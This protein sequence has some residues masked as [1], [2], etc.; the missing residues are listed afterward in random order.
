MPDWD[1]LEQ[2]LLGSIN[3]HTF[4]GGIGGDAYDLGYRR[5]W[6][7]LPEPKEQATA[8]IAQANGIHLRGPAVTYWLAALAM[9][10]FNRLQVA[11][12]LW[13]EATHAPDL[14]DAGWHMGYDQRQQVA[15]WFA[16]HR[17]MARLLMLPVPLRSKHSDEA[18]AQLPPAR[19]EAGGQFQ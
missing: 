8:A 2:T 7:A 9:E 14:A 3:V 15:N 5:L 11:M 6:D 18:W 12:L 1:V 13:V 16:A 17:A 10:D 4:R 19:G